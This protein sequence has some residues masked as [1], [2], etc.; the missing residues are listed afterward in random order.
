MDRRRFVK[1]CGLGAGLAAGAALAASG[2]V[3][4]QRHQRVRLVG[5]D[6][7]PLRASL[8]GVGEPYVF[9]YPFAATP[10]FLVDLGRSVA[11]R[12]GLATE[13]GERYDW[14]GGVGAARSVVAYSAICAHRMAHP[15]RTLSYIS[16]RAARGNGDPDTGVI[17]C[18]AE[19][20]VYDPA[21]GAAVLSGPAP[22]PLATIV[23]EHDPESDA[24]H[25]VGT[26]GG[27]MFQR[28][29]EEFALRLSLEHPSRDLAAP[30]PD[31]VPTLP[32][33]EFTANVVGC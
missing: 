4:A 26:L 20:S 32:L 28:F 10:C 13:Q 15:T 8:L 27:A 18:C 24:L 23:L 21:L 30:L 29:F 25:A 3:R 5:T 19:N 22:Q 1:T 33:S 31:D 11:G 12:L 2:E 9:H 14:P 16:Y 7:A 6:G 17:S